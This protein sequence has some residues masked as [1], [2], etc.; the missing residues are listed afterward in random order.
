MLEEEDDSVHTQHDQHTRLYSRRLKWTLTPLPA[1][2]RL[3]N[4]LLLLLLLL[5]LVVVVDVCC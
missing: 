3:L 5:L 2:E 4:V 1:D